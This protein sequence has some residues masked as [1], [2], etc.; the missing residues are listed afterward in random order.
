MNAAGGVST[1]DPSFVLDI[2][3]GSNELLRISRIWLRNSYDATGKNDGLSAGHSDIVFDTQGDIRIFV[4]TATETE[5]LEVSSPGGQAAART[6][7]HGWASWT[8]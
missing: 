8:A 4:Y 7:A 1:G 3:L 6:E 5:F 2:F